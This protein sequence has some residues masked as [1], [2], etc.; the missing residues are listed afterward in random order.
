MYFLL[1][2]LGNKRNNK[3]DFQFHHVQDKY[4]P[5]PKNFQATFTYSNAMKHSDNCP[6]TSSKHYCQ[7]W[8]LTR[9]VFRASTRNNSTHQ[10][11]L[12]LSKLQFLQLRFKT[13]MDLEYRSH[14]IGQVPYFII[15]SFDRGRISS[16]GRAFDCR[17]GG[18]GFDSRGRTITQGL[19]MT[20]K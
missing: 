10:S 11:C 18:R 9:I 15:S 13:L 14:S 17:A 6:W 7:P 5:Q 1:Y 3:I 16:V 19:K 8:I 20:E 12:H 4:F 2:F